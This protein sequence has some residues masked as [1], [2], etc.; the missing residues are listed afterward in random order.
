MPK[1]LADLKSSPDVGLPERTVKVCVS[2][3][4]A[5]ELE[6]A[7]RALFEAQAALEAAQNQLRAAQ[8]EAQERAEGVRPKL[9]SGETPPTVALEKEVATLEKKAGQAAKHSDGIR[10]RMDEASVA[11]LLRGKPGGEWRL[12][13][14]KHPARDEGEPGHDFDLRWAAGFCDLDALIADLHTFVARYNDEEPSEEWAEFVA[15]NGVPADLR[16]AASVVVGMHEQGVD[17]GKSRGDWRRDR[18]SASA[19]N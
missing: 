2:A 13:A 4:L 14:S 6:E 16:T 9:R 17:L 10:A 1:S 18:M 8:G 12:W 11:L 7:D 5:G 15:A 19:S 3:K